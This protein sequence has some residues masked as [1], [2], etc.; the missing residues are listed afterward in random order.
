MKDMELVGTVSWKA[1]NACEGE[2]DADEMILHR[3]GQFY[4]FR[5]GS[6]PVLR[7]EIMTMEEALA[8]CTERP[9]GVEECWDVP[10]RHKVGMS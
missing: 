4:S 1:V 3:N 8:L 7:P 6:E 5:N 9:H 10:T 2:W